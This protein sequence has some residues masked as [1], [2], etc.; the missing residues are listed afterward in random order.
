MR[1][2]PWQ[3]EHSSTGRYFNPFFA[4][5][6][7]LGWKRPI[8]WLHTTSCEAP[9]PHRPRRRQRWCLRR[10]PSC[11]GYLHTHTQGWRSFDSHSVFSYS[12]SELAN[13]E[14]LLQEAVEA[15][16]PRL[17]WEQSLMLPWKLRSFSSETTS[18]FH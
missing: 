16:P 1:H 3:L 8:C 6:V 13:S 14:G 18:F 7:N 11:H 9:S 12:S 15:F 17:S 2:S 5:R 4:A 10:A